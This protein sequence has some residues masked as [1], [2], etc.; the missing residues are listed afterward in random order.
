MPYASGRFRAWWWIRTWWLGGRKH[1]DIGIYGYRQAGK[2]QFLFNLMKYWSDNDELSPSQ[3]AEPS[4]QAKRF[5]RKV[6]EQ[7]THNGHP[8]P[9]EAKWDGME[10]CWNENLGSEE[11]EIEIRVHDFLGEELDR[12]AKEGIPVES[13]L[14][15][16]VR[17]S[18]CFLFFFNPTEKGDRP[19][20]DDHV[21]LELERVEQ[22][23][24]GLLFGRGLV[25]A[26]GVGMRPLLF[27]ITAKDRWQNDST[28]TRAVREFRD[29][30]QERLRDSWP[31]APRRL[32]E[33]RKMIVEIANPPRPNG[34]IP[35]DQG[36]QLENVV[37]KLLKF[38]KVAR[39]VRLSGLVVLGAVC[40]LLIFVAFFV[41]TLAGRDP[42]LERLKTQLTERVKN[43]QPP[44]EI[45][46]L[47]LHKLLR[48]GCNY[49]H[50]PSQEA[51]EVRQAMDQ[52]G[53]KII[54]EI[55]TIR[56]TDLER[57]L[58]IWNK[59]LGEP[60]R[61][62]ERTPQLWFAQQRFWEAAR[63]YVIHHLG[64]NRQVANGP[65]PSQLTQLRQD[66]SSRLRQAKRTL[67]RWSV[68]HKSRVTVLEEIEES[69]RFLDT[70]RHVI[71]TF[72]AELLYRGTVDERLKFWYG[73]AFHE[74]DTNE[75]WCLK[76]QDYARKFKRPKDKGPVGEKFDVSEL[77]QYFVMLEYFDYRPNPG[78]WQ[79]A[80]TWNWDEIF[81]QSPLS[82]F[83]LPLVGNNTIKLSSTD[84]ELT[85]QIQQTDPDWKSVP[86]LLQ[87]VAESTEN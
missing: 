5:L 60:L 57:Q 21:R 65:S 24:E 6:G 7:I 22:L 63:R 68:P 47:D 73:L 1:L 30:V 33:P 69:L 83:G 40:A 25:L 10:F 13:D 14:A 64:R 49:V 61:P 36:Q 45:S 84:Y 51:V 50:H 44:D 72:D 35:D 38:H 29:G 48:K 2:T 28:L 55:D 66:A 32:L 20:L 85:L 62:S 81:K 31:G 23:L 67:D 4:Q 74:K 54:R 41:A 56:D 9:T 3:Q 46:A 37:R 58:D 59:V 17:K 19:T 87:Q 53:E 52:I 77:G 8:S 16:M 78:K 80:H 12:Q 71:V 70:V 76:P 43:W 18:N 39:Q 15:E 26:K 11:R 75:P 34:T 27:V 79:H 86:S 82:R 42:E